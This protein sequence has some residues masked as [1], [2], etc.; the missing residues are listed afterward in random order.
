MY[1]K[2][3]Y[4]NR[5]G[6]RYSDLRGDHKHITT[7]KLQ[8]VNIFLNHFQTKVYLNQYQQFAFPNPTALKHNGSN[9]NI[10]KIQLPEFP[11]E[12]HWWMP[13]SWLS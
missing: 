9:S 2:L 3:S 12:P 1:I 10:K 13:H 11:E 4:N 6:S 8:N 5:N 7:A